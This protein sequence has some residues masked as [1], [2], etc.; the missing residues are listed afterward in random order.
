MSAEAILEGIGQGRIKA[1]VLVENDPFWSFYDETRL[2]RALERLEF[3]LVLDYVP[4]APVNRAHAVLPTVPVFE[5]T[6]SCFVNQ[7]GRAQ[8]AL[9][10][11]LG[12]TP[13]SLISPDVHPP[14]TFL[15]HVPG[16]DPRTPAEIFR[17]LTRVL[18]GLADPAPVDLWAWLGRQNPI[19]ASIQS[20]AEHPEGMRLLPAT[21]P[22]ND[23]A[24][25]PAPPDAPP[26]DQVELLLVDWTF[27]T[28][29]LASYSHLMAGGGNGAGA[30]D[31][32]RRR[33]E[34]WPGRRQPGRNAPPQGGLDRHREAGARPGAGGGGAPP[35]PS[36]GLAQARRD[37]VVSVRQPLQP[38][39]RVIP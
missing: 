8:A 5:R 17:E 18:S 25:L 33:R 14:R 19:I 38:G 10:V 7:E 4:S 31:P 28:E 3:L 32:S 29:E 30:L 16:G 34:V 15:D 6:A 2:A 27:G 26:P 37:A 22:D 9:P 35:A 13:L 23:F 12:G 36:T 21:R 39:A 11:H 1:L 24:A 20:L